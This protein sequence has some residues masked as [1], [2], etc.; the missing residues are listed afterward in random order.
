VR[1]D[2]V[3]QQLGCAP[4]EVEHRLAHGRQR[5]CQVAS[6]RNVVPAGHGQVG[7]H[8]Q[9]H[10]A[11]GT[12]N[13][14]RDLVIGADDRV[15]ALGPGEQGGGRLSP[16]RLSERALHSRTPWFAVQRSVGVHEPRPAVGGVG[17]AVGVAHESD[18]AIAMAEEMVGERS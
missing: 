8:A 16:I 11:G 12:E 6:R 9:A 13:A 3:T 18:A 4:A 1:R 2:S 10:P 7:G 5:R 17:R 14:H 15:R